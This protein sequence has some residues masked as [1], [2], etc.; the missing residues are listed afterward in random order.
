MYAVIESGGKQYKVA[1]GDKL[2]VEKLPADA[3]A[4]VALGR[5]LM[6]ADGGGIT[7]GA[8]AAGLAVRA[9]VIGHG[10]GDKI[11]VF[12][13]KRRKNYRRTMG[14]RQMYTEIVITA[15]DGGRNGAGAAA[16][17]DTA[18]AAAPE[19]STGAPEA[20]AATPTDATDAGG[21]SAPPA[22]TGDPNH[23]A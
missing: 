18:P 13:M 7:A 10:R 8:P 12:K 16:A 1:V 4:Q 14:H 11:R 9:T 2:R 5:V 21:D 19:T 17:A 15:I 3:G 22:A 20:A 23:G 6:V